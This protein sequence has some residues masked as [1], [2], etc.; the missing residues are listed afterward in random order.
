M[1]FE[2]RDVASSLCKCTVSSGTG[3]FI[4]T[5]RRAAECSTENEYKLYYISKFRCNN[6]L[7]TTIIVRGTGYYSTCT[8]SRRCGPCLLCQHVSYFTL[9]SNL[10]TSDSNTGTRH[11]SREVINKTQE[12]QHTLVTAA[13]ISNIH[14]HTSIRIYK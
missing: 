1:Q 11:I 12:H 13:H 6:V 7:S 9:Y 8:W 2:D 5:H 4:G 14:A 10:R 3:K